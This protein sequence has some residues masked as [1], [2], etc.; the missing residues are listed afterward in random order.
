MGLSQTSRALTRCDSFPNVAGAGGRSG[1]PVFFELEDFLRESSNFIIFLVQQV[2]QSPVYLLLLLKFLRLVMPAA[3]SSERLNLNRVEVQARRISDLRGRARRQAGAPAR[4]LSVFRH[5]RIKSQ[6]QLR[7]LALELLVL[8]FQ[9]L[10]L[11]KILRMLTARCVQYLKSIASSSVLD[12]GL[13]W[14]SLAAWVTQL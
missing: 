10:H 8:L 3:L 2:I 6:I 9:V 13:G 4:T 7:H 11:V 1:M 12:W 5:H 14:P